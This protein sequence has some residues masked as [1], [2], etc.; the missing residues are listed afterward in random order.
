MGRGNLPALDVAF[1][2]RGRNYGGPQI[3]ILPTE[4]TSFFM[5]H[6]KPTKFTLTLQFP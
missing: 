3:R 4:T 5:D 6:F 2:Q 1:S